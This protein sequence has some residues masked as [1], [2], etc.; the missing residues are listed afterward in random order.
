MANACSKSSVVATLATIMCSAIGSFV[1]TSNLLLENEY[2]GGILLTLSSIAYSYRLQSIDKHFNRAQ[3]ARDHNLHLVELF[4]KQYT[5]N[6]SN[7]IL[8]CRQSHS[9]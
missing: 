3:I 4:E 9:K 6:N 8:D 2:V 7:Q 5:Q 1:G